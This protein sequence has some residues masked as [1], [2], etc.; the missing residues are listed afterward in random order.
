M[1]FAPRAGAPRSARRAGSS[2]EDTAAAGRD[3]ALQ[4]AQQGAGKRLPVLY[5]TKRIRDSLFAGPP[6]VYSLKTR[7]GRSYPSYRMVLKRARVG[8]YYGLQATRWRDAP[9]L[10]NPSEKRRIGSRT[11]ELHYDGDR[12]RL[13]PGA[14]ARP[15]T[16]V[17]H[18]V[19][20]LSEREMLAIARSTKAL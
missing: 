8:E 9:I 1:S 5:P 19:Q 10:E 14:R 17:Q 18:P 6:R 4:A 16:A 7:S 13:V 12:L 2:L 20:S 11:Y 15:S 3:Q